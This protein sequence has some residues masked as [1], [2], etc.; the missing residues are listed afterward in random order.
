MCTR[1]LHPRCHAGAGWDTELGHPGP[2]PRLPPLLGRR[3]LSP[4]RRQ[5][6]PCARRHPVLTAVLGARCNPG[7][8]GTTLRGGPW[9]PRPRSRVGCL[10]PPPP[11]GSPRG[12]AACQPAR[13]KAAVPAASLTSCSPPTSAACG[14]GAPRRWRSAACPWSSPSGW[15]A[16]CSRLPGPGCSTPPATSC[17]SACPR[18]R[19][20]AG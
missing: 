6:R 15:A 5:I 8:A 20:P 14:S 10:P 18:S 4:G 2:S 12:A 1:P 11:L 7:R 3:G 13:A 9:A 16:A 17:G 19:T